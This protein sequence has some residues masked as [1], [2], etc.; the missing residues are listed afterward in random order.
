MTV[1]LEAQ[2]VM[3]TLYKAYGSDSGVLFGINSEKV[4]GII[5]QFTLDEFKKKCRKILDD[6][7][8]S[9]DDRMEMVKD[10]IQGDGNDR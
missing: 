2:D 10:I 5:V 4:V 3:D 7:T 6:T 8:L 9:G 1:S